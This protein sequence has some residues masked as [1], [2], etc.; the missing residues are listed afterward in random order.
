MSSKQPKQRADSARALLDAVQV[1][2]D[3][4][5]LREAFWKALAFVGVKYLL[6]VQSN[7][8]DDG[9]T[10]IAPVLENLPVGVNFDSLK[11]R[12]PNLA[13]MF[14]EHLVK[15]GRVEISAAKCAEYPNELRPIF[16]EVVRLVETPFC[17]AIP[18]F[19]EGVLRGGAFFMSDNAFDS[20]QKEFL[21]ALCAAGH[22][23]LV[24]LNLLPEF[25]PLTAR[26]REVLAQ[27]AQGKSDWEIAQLLDISPA[28]AHEHIEAA[29][30][31]LGVRTRVQ[32]AVLA[33]QK[34]WI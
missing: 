13:Q 34:G 25:N 2:Q 3:R 21:S 1:A 14:H 32:A 23:R 31:R 28:T 9:A 20:A 7:T 22:E 5:A 17:L 18:A 19:R 8:T 26:Q 27:C 24:A 15:R 16:S 30:K 11:A 4:D 10:E 33:T 12:W 6:V 29:K